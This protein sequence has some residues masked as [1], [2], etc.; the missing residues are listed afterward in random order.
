MYKIFNYLFG[1]DYIIWSNSADEGISRVRKTPDNVIWY[2]RYW[3]TKVADRIT[4][5]NEVI[6]LTCKPEK[7]FGAKTSKS[8]NTEN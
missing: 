8:S 5:P 4:N 6:W 1:W 3:S 2:W 7:Y